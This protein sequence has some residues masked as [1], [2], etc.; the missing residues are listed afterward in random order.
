MN[1]EK[2][3]PEEKNTSD[4]ESNEAKVKAAI[5]KYSYYSKIYP[6]KEWWERDLD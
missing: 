5:K 6:T 3:L 4:Q 2:L 1:E